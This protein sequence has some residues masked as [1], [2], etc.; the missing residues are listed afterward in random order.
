MVTFKAHNRGGFDYSFNNLETL[1]S[2]KMVWNVV[3]RP[4]F[5]ERSRAFIGLKEFMD[6]GDVIQV[7]IYDKLYR[8]VKFEKMDP[9]GGNLYEIH[10]VD[11]ANITDFDIDATKKGQK[12]KIKNRKSYEQMFNDFL[13]FDKKDGE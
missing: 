1:A 4:I 7:G 13:I 2:V 5:K 3:T 8:I 12:V 11:N 6:D 10:R 9:K